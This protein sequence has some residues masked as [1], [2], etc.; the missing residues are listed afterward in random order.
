MGRAA[1]IALA[2]K[3]PFLSH[4]SC[5]PVAKHICFDL[6]YCSQQ[7]RWIPFLVLKHSRS[8]CSDGGQTWSLRKAKVV[9]HKLLTFCTCRFS[10]WFLIA[11]PCCVATWPPKWYLPLQIRAQLDVLLVLAKWGYLREKWKGKEK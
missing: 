9:V 10:S 5:F 4:L 3:G 11:A 8:R 7:N 6:N 2:E 1:S